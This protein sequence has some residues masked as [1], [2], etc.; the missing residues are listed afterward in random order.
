MIDR[1]KTSIAAT[2][3]PDAQ[4]TIGDLWLNLRPMID[5]IMATQ[6]PLVR[7]AWRIAA[8]AITELLDGT[9]LPADR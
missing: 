5:A 2:E 4:S 3:T 8:A 7:I 6:R 1:P 9:Y